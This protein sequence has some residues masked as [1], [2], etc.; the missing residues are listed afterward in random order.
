MTVQISDDAVYEVLDGEAVVLH[1]ITGN[2]YRLNEVGT[3]AWELIEE[4]RDLGRVRDAMLDEF[5]VTPEV[6]DADLA[7]LVGELTAMGLLT[8]S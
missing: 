3:R 7:T 8:T 1:L 2:Y 4:H 6:L 5:D